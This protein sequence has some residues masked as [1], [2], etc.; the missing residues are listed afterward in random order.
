MV[1]EDDPSGVANDTMMMIVPAPMT[2]SIYFLL[3]KEGDLS[4]LSPAWQGRRRHDGIKNTT[5]KKPG[6]LK[7]SFVTSILYGNS[8]VKRG[9]GTMQ[10]RDVVV[11]VLFFFVFTIDDDGNV[12]KFGQRR[13]RSPS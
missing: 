2:N 13:K 1:A 7:G 9:S 10:S 8:T 12:S 6:G 5:T 11:L 3:K 4:L